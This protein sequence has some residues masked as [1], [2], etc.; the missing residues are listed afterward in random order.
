MVIAHGDGGEESPGDG[1]GDVE[2]VGQLSRRNRGAGGLF[3][4][5]GRETGHGQQVGRDVGRLGGR[6]RGRGR[7]NGGRRC[8]FGG[9]DVVRAQATLLDEIL[10]QAKNDVRGDLLVLA[11]R[12][13]EF[14]GWLYQDAGDPTSAMHYS[15]RAMDYAM[16]IGDPTE[17]AYLLMRKSNVASDLGGFDRAIGLSSAA[18]R[19]ARRV[20]PRVRALVLA[21]QARAHSLRGDGDD[22]RRAIEA[23]ASEV[24][25][26]DESTDELSSYCTP[27]YI[28]MQAA[29]CWAELDAPGEAVPVFEQALATMPS[30][31]RRDQGLCETRLASVHAALGDKH[32]ACVIGRQAVRTVRSATSARAL[33]EL[34][35]LRERLALWRRDEEVSELSL[36]IKQLTTA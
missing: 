6:L 4:L 32:T 36:A 1:R 16:A 26:S 25:R 28:D 5:H 15:D 34:R 13:N 24:E 29:T 21:Q 33:V 8:R 19:E 27:A 10:P 2:P 14:A 22:A 9:D 20:S 35:R 12:Y 30:G 11:C 31:M 18:L 7:G 23:A 17:T 3:V